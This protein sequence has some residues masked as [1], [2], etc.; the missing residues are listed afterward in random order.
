MKPSRGNDEDDGGLDSL[1]DTMTNVVGILVLV[2]IVTQMSVAEVVTRITTENKVDEESVAELNQQ[3]EIERT[4]LRDLEKILVN[5]IDIDEEKL[6]TLLEMVDLSML[7]SDLNVQKN[8]E[9]VLSL[10]QKQR[11]AIARLWYHSPRYAILDECT[12]A[13][14]LELEE[15]LYHEC[16]KRNII[17]VTIDDAGAKQAALAEAGVHCIAV[18][19]NSIRLVTHLD[20]D[21][22]MIAHTVAAFAALAG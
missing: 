21:D 10:G 11:L 1:L 4:E 20:I 12:S 13:V 8:W 2:L 17:Y 19:A 5:P 18:A 9:K 3:L 15:L 6:K 16:K 7:H 22:A 14:S